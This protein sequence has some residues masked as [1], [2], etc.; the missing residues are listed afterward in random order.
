MNIEQLDHAADDFITAAMNPTSWAS[1]LDSLSKASN[2][3]GTVLLPIRGRVPGVPLSDGAAGMIEEYFKHGWQ[4]RDFRE[5]GL[6]RMQQTG[7]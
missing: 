1:A 3:V 2:A 4:T 7:I 6:A 5:H